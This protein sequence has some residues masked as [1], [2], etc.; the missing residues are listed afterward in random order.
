MNKTKKSKK[1]NNELL[2]I[3]IS[4]IASV[5]ILFILL[6][7]IAKPSLNIKGNQIIEINY[8]D[9]YKDKGATSKYFG[10]NID[11]EIKVKGNVNT[12]KVGNYIITYTIRK[13]IFKVEKQR[14]VKVIDSKEPS[15]ELTGEDKIS[16]C[17][18][19]DFIEPGYIGIDEY[20][21]DIT[22]N[23]KTTIKDDKVIY[24]LKD[25]SN[26]EVKKIR[27][28]IKSDTEKPNLELKG[29][30]STTII[31][32]NKYNEPGYTAIDNCDGDITKNVKVEGKVDTSKTGK[33][34]LKYSITDNDENITSKERIIYVKEL[35]QKIA[36]LNYHFFYD[37]NS[38]QCNESICIEINNFRKH[39]EYLKNNNFKTLTMKEFNDWMDKKISIP[40]KSVLITIDD[41]ALGT[42][43]HLPRLLDEYN[44]KATLFLITEW[45]PL[46]KYKTGNLEIQ[47]HGNDLHLNNYCRNNSCGYKLQK[48][49]KKELI[50]DLNKS[51][52]KI[53]NPIAFCYPFYSYN[54]ISIEALKETNFKL[55]FIGG[56]KKASQSSNKYLIP[57]YVIYK[58]T[59]VEQ[60]AKMVN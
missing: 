16:I 7:T 17:P 36:V 19:K 56:N 58:G 22:K 32:N 13:N 11:K 48:L 54:S 41:G 46:S 53:G 51:K 40:N 5:L 49:T 42:D 33:Y 1:I 27:T 26:N 25:S 52:S 14:I 24:T 28:I 20:D 47:S 8:N 18:N 43:T 4:I 3:I 23:V 39:L 60:L 45:W 29:N 15:L 35:P 31:K 37:K 38:E 9:V 50:D 12:K 21:G 6:Y 10:K 57:R 34:I 30:Q 2:V 55:A 59:S 44:M